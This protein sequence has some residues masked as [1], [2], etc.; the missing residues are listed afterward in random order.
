MAVLLRASVNVRHGA[1]R[2]HGLASLPVPDTQVRVSAP[3]GAALSR[4]TI[5]ART[6]LPGRTLRMVDP[7]WSDD[8]A[9]C[10]LCER[11]ALPIEGN[12]DRRR[13]SA[14][15]GRQGLLTL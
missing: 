12:F 4:S 10:G 11:T 13:R 3:A 14:N 8:G 6:I 1:S 7:L 15:S 2:V 9:R 5:A